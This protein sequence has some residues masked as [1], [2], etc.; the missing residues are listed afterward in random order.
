MWVLDAA[1]LG[2]QELT[3]G[4]RTPVSA[5]ILEYCWDQGDDREVLLRLVVDRVARKRDAR[6]SMPSLAITAQLVS[7]LPSSRGLPAT[8]SVRIAGP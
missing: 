4:I 7:L 6:R 2:S 5:E 1:V 8:S 3:R